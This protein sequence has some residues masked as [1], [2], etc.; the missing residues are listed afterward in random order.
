[1]RTILAFVTVAYF[2]VVTCAL[3]STPNPLPDP[4][5]STYRPSAN[6]MP[7]AR[8]PLGLPNGWDP[9]LKMKA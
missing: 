5:F 7:Y 1:M 6:V 8:M 3:G 9:T 4:S 2:A